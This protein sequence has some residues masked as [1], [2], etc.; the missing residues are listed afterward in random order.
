MPGELGL[1]Q[2][3][4]FEAARNRQSGM[5][6]EKDDRRGAGDIL[7]DHRLGIVGAKQSAHGIT[8][9]RLRVIASPSPQAGIVPACN[10]DGLFGQPPGV[11]VAFRLILPWS[12]YMMATGLLG[13]RLPFLKAILPVTAG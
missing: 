5:I 1:A 3:Q 4:P 9:S 13:I 10:I 6:G 12:S 2:T 7:Q 8:L 11:T